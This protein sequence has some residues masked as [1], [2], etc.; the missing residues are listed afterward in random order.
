MTT[1]GAKYQMVIDRGAR[2][3]LGVQPGWVAVQ[4]V[5]GD[6]LE[7]RFLPPEHD[8]SLAGSLRHYA[9]RRR[10]PVDEEERAAWVSEVEERWGE[11]RG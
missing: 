11:A 1:V 10:L 4:T 5:V 8:E 2:R 9:P 7:V 3:R 6:H